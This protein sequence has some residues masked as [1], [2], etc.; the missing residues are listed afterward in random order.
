M[1]IFLYHDRCMSGLPYEP[2]VPFRPNLK[3]FVASVQTVGVLIRVMN[4][5]LWP[6]CTRYSSIQ[7]TVRPFALSLQCHLVT[8][9]SPKKQVLCIQNFSIAKVV[10]GLYG[11][12]MSI[13]VERR[14]FRSRRTTMERYF[15]LFQKKECCHAINDT[16]NTSWYKCKRSCCILLAWSIVRIL[17]YPSFHIETKK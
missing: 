3:R 9:L 13:V 1:S 8:Y 10:K 15:S 14:T 16:P 17:Y 7:F 11:S 2:M 4:Q 12:S 6:Y 5:W